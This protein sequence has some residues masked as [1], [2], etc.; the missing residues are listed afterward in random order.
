MG[1]NSDVR[2]FSLLTSFLSPSNVV[3]SP[4]LIKLWA[5]PPPH[6]VEHPHLRPNLCRSLSAGDFEVAKPTK[7]TDNVYDTVFGFAR[8]AGLSG[9]G[10]G[11]IEHLPDGVKTT[12]EALK[13]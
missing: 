12:I 2:P 8:L 3:H 9:K 10:S 5:P 11:R 13:G 4:Q 6:F 1:R 7:D